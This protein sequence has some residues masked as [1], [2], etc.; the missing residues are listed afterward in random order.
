[1][2]EETSSLTN[3]LNHT[4]MLDEISCSRA[5][6]TARLLGGARLRCQ[7]LAEAW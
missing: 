1:M 2:V 5:A 6:T 4:Q 3:A 7:P